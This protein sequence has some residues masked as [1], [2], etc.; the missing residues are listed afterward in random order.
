M[1]LKIIKP[2]LCNRLF[3]CLL[4]SLLTTTAGAQSSEPVSEQQTKPLVDEQILSEPPSTAP[5]AA[6]NAPAQA[7]EQVDK[8]GL[9]KSSDEDVEMGPDSNAAP[10]DKLT[11]EEQYQIY[12]RDNPDDPCDR[13]MDTYDYAESWYDSSQVYVN[14]RFCEPA[15]WFDN[16]FANDRIFEEGVAGTYIRWRNEFTFD[17]E[18][19]FKFK[20]AL[21]ASV[22]LPVA[23]KKLRLTFDDDVDEDLR[24]IAPGQG[25]DTTNTLGLQLDLAQNDR[26]KFNVSVS[27][28]PKIR[29]RY[30]YTY[31]VLDTLILRYTQEIQRKKQI[32]SA[33]SRIDV[34]KLFAREF[35]FRS[36]TEG[37]L[38]E[39]F[40]GVDWLQ[41]FVLYQR[42][43]HKTSISYESSA[44]G[45]TEPV[46][47]A[48]N[49]RL[50]LRFRK[51]FHREWLF[52][53]ISK[54]W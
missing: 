20:T 27:L 23:E 8:Q 11:E 50:G 53:E 44:S 10:A 32:N 16:F 9:D 17:E 18:E 49:Y 21:N 15:L 39:E 19:G 48:V 47:Q 33:L 22:E 34:E 31:P 37:N 42:I 28:S 51:N 43:N 38:S 24:D 12:R 35:L 29:F 14:A 7:V 5:E 41:A 2:E 36:T 1:L 25:E 54:S 6:V 30:R 46:V 45:M 40:D 13:S 3:I 4:F 52:Y 26:S